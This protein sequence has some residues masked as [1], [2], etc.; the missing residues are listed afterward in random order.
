MSICDL[1]LDRNVIEDCEVLKVLEEPN[2]T[3]EIP[4]RGFRFLESK[5]LKGWDQVFVEPLG[6]H[7]LGHLEVIYPELP[8]AA[9]CRKVIEELNCRLVGDVGFGKACRVQDSEPLDEWK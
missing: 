3:Q 8:E 5:G 6:F 2:E 4:A 9:E 7:E 1:V